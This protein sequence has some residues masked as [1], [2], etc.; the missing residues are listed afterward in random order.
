MSYSSDL[1][2]FTNIFLFLS[3][4]QSSSAEFL[5]SGQC[6]KRCIARI[7]V[8]QPW[9]VTCCTLFSLLECESSLCSEDPKGREALEFFSTAHV[10]SQN[11]CLSVK[12]RL[13]SR[14]TCSHWSS[15][16]VCG[17][18]VSQ[19]EQMSKRWVDSHLNN[20]YSNTDSSNNVDHNSGSHK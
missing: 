3:V 5:W 16:G 13:K 1:L 20:L 10:S 9:P 7:Q 6:S 18:L 11:V 19:L 17:D 15:P 12:H 14:A 8:T 2:D 4:F